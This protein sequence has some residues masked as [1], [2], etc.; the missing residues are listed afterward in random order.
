MSIPIVGPIMKAVDIAKGIFDKSISSFNSSYDK[1]NDVAKHIFENKDKYSYA[2]KMPSVRE[3]EDSSM[4][5]LEAQK[6]LDNLNRYKDR[7]L[8]QDYRNKFMDPAMEA[9]TQPVVPEYQTESIV[10]E[11]QRSF[12]V[13]ESEPTRVSPGILRELKEKA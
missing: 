13:T 2:S 1:M 11:Y 10:P 9:E 4:Q 8:F 7:I 5:L 3:A 12:E 6:R